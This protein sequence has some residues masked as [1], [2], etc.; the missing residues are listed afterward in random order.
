MKRK[1]LLYLYGFLIVIATAVASGAAGYAIGYQRG[2]DEPRIT[3]TWDTIEIPVNAT[4]F[5]WQL[6]R[7]DMYLGISEVL[8]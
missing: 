6:S 3:Y 2:Y 8:K 4:C 1:I 7:H 5:E